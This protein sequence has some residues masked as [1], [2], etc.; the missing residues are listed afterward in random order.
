MEW[1]RNK[2]ETKSSGPASNLATFLICVVV[3]IL[4]IFVCK[5]KVTGP[6]WRTF[7]FHLQTKAYAEPQYLKKIK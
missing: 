1:K 2:R 7:L 6:A 4:S 5:T 3:S